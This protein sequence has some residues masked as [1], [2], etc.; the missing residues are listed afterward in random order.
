MKK[1][2]IKDVIKDSIAWELGIA[3]G[4]FLLSV[5]GDEIEDIFD[6]QFLC[7]DAYL[8]I[9]VEDKNGQVKTFEIEKEEDED[10]GLVFSEGLMDEYHSCCNKCIFCF[11]D[12]MPKG[13]RDTLYFKDDD[14]RLSFLQGN[15]VTLTNMSDHDVERI[16]KYRLEPI[17]I[18]FQTTNP[19]LRCK[20]LTNRFAGDALK[21]AD[22]FYEASITMN[23][24]IVLCKGVNDGAELER[25]LS[26]L[27]K[28]VPVLE[29]LSVVPVG[30]SK[31][32]DGLYPLEPFTKED[33]IE[34]IATIEKWQNKA[35][36]EHGIHFVHASDEWYITAGKKLPEEDSYD[37]Y[38]QIENGVGMIRSMLT[39]YEIYSE[40]LEEAYN[41][42]IN[43]I[44]GLFNKN[45]L[46]E[47]Y[48]VKD[49]KRV[50]ELIDKGGSVMSVSGLIAASYMQEMADDFMKKFPNFNIKV[51]PIRNEFFGENITVTGLLTGQ[52]IINQIK[53][54]EHPDVLLLPENLL[55]ADTDILLDDITVSDIESALHL[56]C[57]IVKSNGMSFIESILGETVYV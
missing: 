3:P 19:E 37:G 5:N 56:K 28:Y 35:Y 14:L 41:A 26:D 49:I 57:R 20:M 45:A 31:Y 55:K 17:N 38:L 52:D 21:K 13:M 6:Y 4:D 23:G 48:G 43:P 22:R 44:K 9:G 10:T 40:L 32:R 18:S 1:H 25:S 36:E 53:E 30:L 47:E 29:S 51:V 42:K 12:Q 15:Y 7:Q 16:I 11:I 24:Q 50:K 8:T 2:E 39:E 46:Q 54:I 27:Y 34:V 33:A